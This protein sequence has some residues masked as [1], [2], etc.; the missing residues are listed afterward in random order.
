MVERPSLEGWAPKITGDEFLAEVI[1]QAFDYRGDVT[2]AMRDGRRQVGYV[3]N[4]RRD[5]SCPY[6]EILPAAGGAPVVI[7]YADIQGIA[8]TGRDTAAG[9]S[10][11]AWLKRKQGGTEATGVLPRE[12]STP[13]G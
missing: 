3:F 12:P 9:N 11:E 13:G 6:I 4:R 1:E 7:A 2:V 5:V 10:Y 8:F